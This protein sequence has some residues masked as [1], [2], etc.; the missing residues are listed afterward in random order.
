MYTLNHAIDF[1][2]LLFLNK[3][4]EYG[5]FLLR[6]NYNR[7]LSI[8]VI[9]AVS[10]FILSISSPILISYLNPKAPAIPHGIKTISIT[11]IGPPPSIDDKSR[12]IEKIKETK[13]LKST[14]AFKPPVIRP[15]ELVK[16]EYVPAQIDF[17]RADPGKSTV[18]GDASAPDGSLIET[19]EA[20]PNKNEGVAKVEVFTY[21][22]EMPTFPGGPDAFL[23]Y[24]AQKIQYPEIAKRAGVEGRV[25]VS[26]VVS[27]SGNISDVQVAKSIGAGCDEEAVRVIK[28]M[29]K[30]NPGKQ[31]GRPVNVQVSVP[32]VF[33]LQ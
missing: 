14:I 15:D 24:V 9:M 25:S 18:Q 21:V 2:E 10:F 31:N 3:N 19:E 8:A 7:Y 4:K 1:D 12:E 26:F 6:K 20:V 23:S 16:D 30:W 22:E 33:R 13:Q 11:E 28:S 32:I 17:L 29:P 5:A 27:P